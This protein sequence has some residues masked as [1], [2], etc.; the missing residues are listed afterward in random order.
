MHRAGIV[1]LSAPLTFG[2]L[3]PQVGQRDAGIKLRDQIPLAVLA[4][5]PASVAQ[6]APCRQSSERV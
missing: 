3:M 4:G 6:E 1:H 5:A 2:N